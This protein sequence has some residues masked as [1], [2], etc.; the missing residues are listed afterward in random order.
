MLACATLGLAL[1]ACQSSSDP[2]NPGTA[3]LPA[4]VGPLAT[5]AVLWAVGDTIHVDDRVI[6]VGKPVRAM[7][8]AN[9]RI[10][11]LQGLSDVVWVTDGAAVRSTSLRADELSVSKNNRY[12]GLLD[13]SD[14]MPWSTVIV[15]LETGEVVVH[16]D[17]GMGDAEDDL[18][19]LYEDAEPRVL[20][21]DGDELFVRTASGLVMSWDPRTGT[22]TEHHR[23]YDLY[24][25][26][27]RDP[28]GGQQLPALVRDGRLVVP[29]DPYRSTQPGH[30]S[31]DGSVALMPVDGSSQVFDVRSGRRLP[32]DLHGRKF[33]LGGWTDME[34]AYGIAFDRRPRGPHRVRLVSCRLTLEQ[35]QCR[36]LR[37]IRAP[38][39]ELVLF[40][41][42]LAASDY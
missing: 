31:P 23:R 12:L 34:T 28:G 38:A 19:D 37:T 35:R 27:R 13:K 17:A 10:Y 8:E 24:Y 15:D 41:T 5:D 40:P 2:T 20:G 42:G 4:G 1:M 16:D 7:V 11:L 3:V 36:V 6:R 21:F 9:G 33:I 18:A 32:A 22:P 39:H 25:F 29:R 26:A 30:V 14:G